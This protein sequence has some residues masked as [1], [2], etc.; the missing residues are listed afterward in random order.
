MFVRVTCAKRRWCARAEGLNAMTDER[1]VATRAQAK[2]RKADMERL[3]EQREREA[4]EEVLGK[5]RDMASR[6]SV[7]ERLKRHA[8][9]EVLELTRALEAAEKDKAEVTAALEE[10]LAT[11]MVSSEAAIEAL[12]ADVERANGAAEALNEDNAKLEEENAALLEEK[13]A[14]ESSME[15]LT[16]TL[17]DVRASFEQ[18]TIAKSHVD[19]EL[20]ETREELDKT[21][22]ELEEVTKARLQCERDLREQSRK[23]QALT[24]AIESA[25][26]NGR[27]ARDLMRDSVMTL[28]RLE[29]AAK[30]REIQIL[31]EHHAAEIQRMQEEFAMA[32]ADV[33]ASTGAVAHTTVDESQRVKRAMREVEEDAREAV[34]N[35]RRKEEEAQRAANTL[36]EELAMTKG[37]LMKMIEAGEGKLDQAS[38]REAQAARLAA[39]QAQAICRDLKAELEAEMESAESARH[40]ASETMHKYFALRDKHEQREALVLHQ[41]ETIQSL[42]RDVDMREADIDRL[43]A[44]LKEAKLCLRDNEMTY[45]NRQELSEEVEHLNRVLADANVRDRDRALELKR[46]QERADSYAER[47]EKAES[48]LCEETSKRAQLERTMRDVSTT[49]SKAEQDMLRAQAMSAGAV[50]LEAEV[51]R[52]TRVNE[53]AEARIAELEHRVETLIARADDL[54]ASQNPN[55]GIRYLEQLREEREIASKDAEDAGK[56]VQSMR[57]ALQF[58]CAASHETR[59]NVVQYAK[60]ARKTG[61]IFTDAPGLPV[62]VAADIWARVI[63]TVARLDLDAMQ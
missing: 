18:V 50:L 37:R 31:K 19:E 52:L 62:G 8:E 28:D 61:R 20:K 22:D 53:Q 29:D 1:R 2:A 35:A 39:S 43:K 57:A 23:A 46:E 45:L 11:E 48:Q 55:R 54:A 49:T 63:D 4:T 56:A 21:R 17:R 25:K 7:A 60:E 42:K 44:Q 36:R 27:A 58:V 47:L 16:D 15:E 26:G 6:T 30:V 12:T 38:I 40:E 10:R 41:K 13:R 24:S 59:N 32:L 14:A 5:S 51:L 33:K 34:R 9:R 3:R